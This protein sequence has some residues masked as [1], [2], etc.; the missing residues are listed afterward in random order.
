M[1]KSVESRHVIG[2][3]HPFPYV[4]VLIFKGRCV[5]DSNSVIDC[6]AIA[7]DGVAHH[8]YRR[9]RLPTQKVDSFVYLAKIVQFL[10]ACEIHRRQ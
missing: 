5:Y 9:T 7:V 1:A 6:G 3:R 4:V 10:T 2:R 8:R